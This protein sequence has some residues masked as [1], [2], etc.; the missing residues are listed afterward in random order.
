MF[1]ILDYIGTFV[2]AISGVLTGLNKKL[3]LFGVFVVAFVTAIGGGT[4]R[5]ILI[6]RTPVGWMENFQYVYLIIAG[7]FIAILFRKKL[8]YLRVSMFLF[9]TIGLGVFT[10]IGIE[11]GIE[12]GLEPVICVALGTITATFG[13]VI[14][15]ILC[16]DIP[17]IF[18]REIYATVCFLGGILFFLLRENVNQEVLYV[19]VSLFMICI[20]ILAVKKKWG[21]PTLDRN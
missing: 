2:F 19:L 13:G 11:K 12:K 4:L 20:R 7:F 6:G 5:D 18:R 16:N 10:I 17:V 9:D 8:D 21:L 1:Q 14:R 15:D 3:D